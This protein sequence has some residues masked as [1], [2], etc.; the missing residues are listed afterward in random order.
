AF[1]DRRHTATPSQV[2][3]IMAGK[4]ALC[5][6]LCGLRVGRVK[7]WPVVTRSPWLSAQLLGPP[8]STFPPRFP[9][10][11]RLSAVAVDVVADCTSTTVLQEPR[12]RLLRGGKVAPS[13]DR[14]ATSRR[15]LVVS[16]LDHVD[17]PIV[18]HA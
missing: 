18:G 17:A 14:S 1:A 11:V 2:S 7:P 3:G 10:Q 15:R 16:T 8:R 5:I 4:R 6:Y 13:D 9:Q 12:P